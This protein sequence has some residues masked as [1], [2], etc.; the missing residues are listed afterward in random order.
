MHQNVA[1]YVKLVDFLGHALGPDYEIALHDLSEGNYSIVAIAN[2]FN[3]NRQIGA[4]LTKKALNFVESG[5]YKTQDYVERYPGVTPKLER[6]V[7]STMFIKDDDQQLVGMLCVNYNTTRCTDTV[8]KVLELCNISLETAIPSLS[9]SAPADVPRVPT[10]A[11]EVFSNNIT[12]LISS[13]LEQSVQPG[14]PPERLNQDEKMEIIKRLKE[15]GVFSVKGA[16]REVATQLCCSEPT[17]YRYLKN[18]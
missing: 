16:V 8:K 13:I 4:P 9:T 1:Q 5:I 12:E 11:P 7:S 10:E 6:T 3:S 14:T 2:G 18:T 17:I 15:C